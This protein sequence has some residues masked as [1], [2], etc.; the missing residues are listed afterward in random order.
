[1]QTPKRIILLVMG[2]T[3]CSSDWLCIHHSRPVVE[4]C[5]LSAAMQALGIAL[6]LTVGGDN[7]LMRRE[8]AY[9]AVVRLSVRC[10]QF[11]NVCMKSCGSSL[12][13]CPI[14][15]YWLGTGFPCTGHS[16]IEIR[17]RH[18]GKHARCPDGQSEWFGGWRRSWECA[19]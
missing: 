3:H 5:P 9:C 8:T 2:E 1:M 17:Y 12:G 18:F 4:N 6:K 14:L 16:V 15:Y 11:G 10:L 13:C 19:W 7:Q